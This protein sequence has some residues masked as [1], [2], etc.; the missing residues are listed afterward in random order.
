L[1]RIFLN[2]SRIKRQNFLNK[3]KQQI[4]ANYRKNIPLQIA[5]FKEL[6]AKAVAAIVQD[7]TS[8]VNY[9]VDDLEQQLDEML[10]EKRQ[11]E[12]FIG[13]EVERLNSYKNE[14]LSLKST[15]NGVL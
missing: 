7:L 11:E 5:K 13:R 1:A 3:I 14:L 10:L 6:Y 9:R 2:I 12:E 4:D 8:H 15:L